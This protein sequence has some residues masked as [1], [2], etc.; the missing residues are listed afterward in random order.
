VAYGLA[1]EC[2][3]G[4]ARCGQRGCPRCQGRRERK[5]LA[6]VNPSWFWRRRPVWPCLLLPAGYLGLLEIDG[7]VYGVLPLG[8]YPSYGFR[9]TKADGTVYDVDTSAPWGWQCDC[10]DATY[11]PERPGGCKHAG[12]LRRDIEALFLDGGHGG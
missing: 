11:R 1:E 12:G 6:P 10:A 4:G 9:L 2:T 3:Q 8:E 7:Q 5:P